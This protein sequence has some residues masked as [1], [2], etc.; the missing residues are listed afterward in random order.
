MSDEIKDNGVFGAWATDYDPLIA[1][2]SVVPYLDSLVRKGRTGYLLNSR[3]CPWSLL[4]EKKKT[5]ELSL[6]TLVQARRSLS[7][8]RLC[9]WFQVRKGN[10]SPVPDVDTLYVNTLFTRFIWKKSLSLDT[11]FQWQINVPHQV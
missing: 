9:L 5:I 4:V 2:Q 11:S 10:C 8:Y 3:R 1:D 7:N 6:K